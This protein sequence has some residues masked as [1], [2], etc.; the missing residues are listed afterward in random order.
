MSGLQETV[1]AIRKLEDSTVVL[2]VREAGAVSVVE[3]ID[4]FFTADAPSELIMTR[5][6]QLSKKR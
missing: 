4:D 2:A 3:G 1:R 6:H 5:A